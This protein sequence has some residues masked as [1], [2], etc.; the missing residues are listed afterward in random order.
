MAMAAA[1]AGAGAASSQ[2]SREFPLSVSGRVADSFY[3]VEVEAA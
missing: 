1:A 3:N 2:L